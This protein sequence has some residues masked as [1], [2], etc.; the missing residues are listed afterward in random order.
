MFQSTPRLDAGKSPAQSP[1]AVAQHL[2]TFEALDFD[3]FSHQQWKQLP[4]SHAANILVHWPDGHTT[5]GLRRH[6][7]DLKAMFVYAP[8]TRITQQPIEVGQGAF[9]AVT[10]IMTA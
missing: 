5:T 6:A 1:N 10:G 3:V 8:D 7:E 9:T 2:K 4:E